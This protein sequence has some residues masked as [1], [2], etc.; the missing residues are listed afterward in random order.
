MTGQ[1]FKTLVGLSYPNA[2]SLKLIPKGGVSKLS[3][4]EQSKIKYKNVAAGKIVDDLPDSAIK[5]LLKD[6]LIVEAKK[7][8]KK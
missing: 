7:G 3:P 1:S 5:W 6:E 8:A 4:E 2:A